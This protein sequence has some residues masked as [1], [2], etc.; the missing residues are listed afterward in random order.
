M[1][2]KKKLIIRIIAG[3]ILTGAIIVTIIR[4]KGPFAIF[5]LLGLAILW[6]ADIGLLV[7]LI[8]KAMTSPKKENQNTL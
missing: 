2:F 8:R 3:V 6:A 7:D 1:S 5:W 4:P